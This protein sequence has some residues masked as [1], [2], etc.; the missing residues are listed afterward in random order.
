MAASMAV[1]RALTSARRAFYRLGG[2]WYRRGLFESLGSQRYSRPALHGMDR[3]LEALV[4]PGPGVFVEAGAHDGFTQSN[5][6][7]L[8]RHRGWRGLL[9]EPV[10]ELHAKA[11]RRRRA[12]VVNAALVGPEA[13]G[14]TVP[15]QFGDLMSTVRDQPG[16]A[17]AGLENAGRRA[18]TAHVPARTL[19]SLLDEAGLE[20]VDLLVLDVEGHEAEALRGLDLDRHA[21][22]LILL[23]L[24]DLPAQRPVF[25]ALLGE[26]YRFEQELSPWDALY[27]KREP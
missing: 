24:L 2:P 9:V 11:R 3:R 15:I 21:P 22:S 8:E 23:E 27:R 4:P 5:T 18:Y 6:Y 14:T 16:H 12:Q 26:R 13:E 20:H 10:P 1:V 17:A 7:Y 19:S 25:D